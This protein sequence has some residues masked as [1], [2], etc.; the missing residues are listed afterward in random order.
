LFEELLDRGFIIMST[1]YGLL[2]ES[3]FL[4]RQ[5]QD[6]RDVG[7]W[8]INDLPQNLEQE[9]GVHIQAGK[10]VVAGASAGTLLAL[11]TVGIILL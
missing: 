9:A 8:I 3:S 7:T 5:L 4:H 2:P 6:I 1:D 11:L 10:I